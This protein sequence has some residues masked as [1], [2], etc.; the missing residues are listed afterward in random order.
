M[1]PSATIV[2]TTTRNAGTLSHDNIRS[3]LQQKMK[4]VKEDCYIEDVFPDKFVYNDG[5]G[6]MHERK[7]SI[8]RGKIAVGE[9]EREV[10]RVT[11]YKPVG[12][13]SSNLELNVI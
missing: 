11:E 12:G 6:K 4:G 8:K 2:P 10:V 3:M 1:N 13:D 7:Y 5:K 9:S